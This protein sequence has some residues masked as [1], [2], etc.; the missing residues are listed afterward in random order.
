MLIETLGNSDA[1]DHIL[2]IV[3]TMN[4]TNHVKITGQV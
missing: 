1:Y 4:E 3:S 2:R